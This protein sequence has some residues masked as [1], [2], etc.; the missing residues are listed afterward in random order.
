[1]VTVRPTAPPWLGPVLD[2]VPGA[3]L[4]FDSDGQLIG[5]NATAR[6]LLA[7]AEAPTHHGQ[8]ALILPVEARDAV[9]RVLSGEIREARGELYLG[10][11]RAWYTAAWT[12]EN[13]AEPVVLLVAQPLPPLEREADLLSAASHELKTPLTAIKGA[14]QLLQRRAGR[15][16][17]LPERDAHLLDLLVAQV[18]RLSEVIDGVVEASR[19]AAGRAQL[20]IETRDLAEVVRD[21]VRAFERSGLA[22]PVTLDIPK[23]PVQAA[24]DSARIRRVMRALLANAAAYSAAGQ[25]ITVTLTGGGTEALCVSV[26]D[27]GA[28]VPEADR[29]RIFDRFYRGS[30][31]EGGLGLGLY[32]AAELVRLHGGAL[33]LVSGPDD[34][35]SFVF[36]LPIEG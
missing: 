7:P 8:D 33:E 22:S 34:G 13:R 16:A 29:P 18:D 5:A 2:A 23:H 31:T 20:H 30:N 14:A 10:G 36:T 1:M 32:I 28:G 35:S 27:R 19:L 4:A 26:S 3:L 21:A 6:R 17:A 15:N 9:R 25:P 11:E 24:F 12:G